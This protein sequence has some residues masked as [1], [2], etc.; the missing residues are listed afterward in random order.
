MNTKPE[1]NHLAL[2]DT[3]SAKERVVRLSELLRQL[4]ELEKSGKIPLAMLSKMQSICQSFLL[5]E[6][7]LS[8]KGKTLLRD[9]ENDIKLQ[10]EMY[11]VT[12]PDGFNSI[13]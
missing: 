2:E 8:E 3:K 11:S 6:S 5:I 9:S 1:Q 13:N 4:E 10:L 7:E 12:N